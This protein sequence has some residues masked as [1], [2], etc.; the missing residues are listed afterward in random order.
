MEVNTRKRNYPF[1]LVD[2]QRVDGEEASRILRE[3]EERNLK[4]ENKWTN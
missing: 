2:G 1:I 4:E 3:C